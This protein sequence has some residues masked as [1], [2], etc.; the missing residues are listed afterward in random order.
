MHPREVSSTPNPRVSVRRGHHMVPLMPGTPRVASAESPWQGIVVERHTVGAVEIPE[1]QHDSFCLHLQL[2][3]S[4]GMEYWSEGRNAVHQPG[5]GSMI[6]LRPGTSDRLRWEGI[7][8][9]LIVS[10]DTAFVRRAA[11]QAGVQSLPSF[12]NQWLLHD[13]ALQSLLAEMGRETESGWAAGALYGDLLGLS[14]ASTLLRRHASTPVEFE[15]VRGG[16]PL[17]RLRRVLEY[18][19]A[20][21][22]DDLRL[23]QLAAEAGLSEFHFA[24]LFRQST[25]ITP[26]QYVLQQRIER[27]QMLLK[28]GH[29][30]INEVAAE[31]GFSSATNFVRS[32]RTRVGVTPGEWHSA[33]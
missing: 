13:S 23:D 25:G 27:A 20:H 19:E 32:F 9:R 3:G 6:L 7:S 17:P 29:L 15:P 8:E 2:K 31:T 16:I 10:L 11:E 33:E 21:L 1:H 30:S 5:P 26:H 4:V 14:L 28:L 22:A 18:M 24:R 12:A